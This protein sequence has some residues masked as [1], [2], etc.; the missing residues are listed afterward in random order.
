MYVVGGG[1]LPSTYPV[2]PLFH[3]N[4]QRISSALV[5]VVMVVAAVA[6]TTTTTATATTTTTTT[7]M[8]V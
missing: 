5:V 2:L 1:T 3:L 4:P 7:A 8:T 6:T